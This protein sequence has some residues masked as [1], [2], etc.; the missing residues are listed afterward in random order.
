MVG[1]RKEEGEGKE[2]LRNYKDFRYVYR[3]IW[4]NGNSRKH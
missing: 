2:V 1:N 3:T 4:K